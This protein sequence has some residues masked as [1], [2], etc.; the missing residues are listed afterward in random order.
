MEIQ[1]VLFD[2]DNTLTHR[3][4]SIT[5]YSQTFE[6]TYK[7]SLA[8]VDV[9]QIE[10]IIH[11]IDNG[12]YPKV[13]L[14]SHKSIGTSVAHALLEELAWIE[15]PSLNELSDFWFS[16]FGVH[17]VEMA[18]A[19]ELLYALKQ[20][21]FKLAVVS[22]GGHITRLNILKGL[23]LHHLFDE[24]ISSELIG[25]TKPKPE[26]FIETSKRLKVNVE[27]CLFVGDHP[28]ND[29][30]GAINAGMNAVFMEGFH[31]ADF[32]I[33]H[34]IQHLAELRKFM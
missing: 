33:E 5:A 29:I 2:L 22:N 18:G 9:D 1:A 19:K 12:G 13:E 11:R 24:I 21:G 14:L 7:A 27:H 4:K 34:K 32:Y 17:A 6:K 8:Q 20:E 23:G 10:S 31:S 25:I 28:I 3:E 30:Q 26:I 15:Q 16:Q